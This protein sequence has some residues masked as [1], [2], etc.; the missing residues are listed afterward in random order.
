MLDGGRVAA[1]A[2]RRVSDPA[3]AAGQRFAALL[4]ADGIQVTGHARAAVGTGAEIASVVSPP[5]AALVE[6]MLTLSDNDIAEALARHVS[7]KTGG[8][9]TFA[10]GAAAV[11]AT[12]ANMGIPGAQL[13]DGSGLSTQD[14]VT[15]AA[16]AAILRRATER[17]H[18]ELLSLATG[19]PV[20]GFSGTMLR[21]FRDKGTLAYAGLVHA[22]TGTLK[23]VTSLAGT[24]VDRDGRLLVFAFISNRSTP[25][26]ASQSP[27]KG[28]DALI[29]VVAS[30]G[31]R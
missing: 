29:A 4:A 9:G 7:L 1:G 23:N 12:V 3:A 27:T 16:L 31:C 21:R 14:R 18:P 5:V 19:L 10:A 2:D 20:A 30:C 6:R 17:T 25:V 8:A 24:V 26:S 28:L 15:P 13:V 11:S 22:K